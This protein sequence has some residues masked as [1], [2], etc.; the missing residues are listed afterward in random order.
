[1]SAYAGLIGREAQD[2][3]RQWV[4]R[5]VL[6]IA[7]IVASALALV[8]AGVALM[9]WAI[10]P[11]LSDRGLWLLITVPCVPA[12]AAA[13]AL[14]KARQPPTQAAFAALGEQISEDLRLIRESRTP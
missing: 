2:A 4:V 13:L 8:L 3:R 6:Y 10:T 11:E 1:M 7:V 9:L 5:S 14:W 12:L